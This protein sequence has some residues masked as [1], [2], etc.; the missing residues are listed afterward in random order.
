MKNA[1]TLDA[2]A[3]VGEEGDTSKRSALAEGFNE[4]EEV[5]AGHVHTDEDVKLHS[6]LFGFTGF[7][8]GHRS[9]V[10]LNGLEDSSQ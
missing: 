8:M 5:L 7:K 4:E 2:D 9:L 1:L 3:V 10:V 6:G